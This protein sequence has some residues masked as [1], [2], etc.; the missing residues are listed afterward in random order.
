MKHVVKFTA[1]VCCSLAAAS[2]FADPET[3]WKQTGA[4][5]YVYVDPDNW[6]GGDV[7]GIF[8]SDLTLAGNQTITFSQDTTLPD[9]LTFQYD[10]KYAI[11]LASDGTGDK[12][13][14]LGGDI[15]FSPAQNDAAAT[16]TFNVGIDLGGAMRTISAGTNTKP[17][18][19]IMNAVSNGG[20]TLRNNYPLT[21]NSASTYAGGTT[22]AGTG[23]VT[24]MPDAFGTGTITFE[25]GSQLSVS[26]NRTFTVN[27]PLVF[28]GDWR[29]ALSGGNLNLGAGDIS[30][31][32]PVTVTADS[33][34]LTLGGAV[35]QG[36]ITDITK[37]GSGVLSTKAPLVLAGEAELCATAGTWQ[38]GGVISGAGTLV[39]TGAGQ[40]ELLASNTFTDI[41]VIREGSV[42]F[43]AK[44]TIA[45]GTR[46]L[47]ESAGELRSNTGSECNYAYSVPSLIS[48]G[49]IDT[50][51][52][53]TLAF[54]SNETGDIDLTNYPDLK[55]GISGGIF[56][57]T[58]VITAAPGRPYILG[59]GNTL[60]LASDNALSG[61]HDVVLNGS[62]TINGVNNVDG[63]VSLPVGYTFTVGNEAS[64][65]NAVLEADADCSVTFNAG[66]AGSFT[67]LKSLLLRTS[68]LTLGT[69]SAGAVEHIITDG[70]VVDTK[71][72]GGGTSQIAG[73]GSDTHATTLSLGTIV[74][75]ENSPCFL[76]ISATTL[77]DTI[78]IKCATPPDALA[79]NDTVGTPTTPVIPWI[80]ANGAVVKHT[81][82]DGFATLDPASDEAFAGSGAVTSIA[83]PGENLAVVAPA[84]VDIADATGDFNALSARY[85]GTD[86]TAFYA[87]NGTYRL[88]S[89][90]IDYTAYNGDE[91]HANLDLGANRGYFTG[92]I[93][94][95]KNA[96]GKMRLALTG[97]G[98]VSFSDCQASPT[99]REWDLHDLGSTYSGDTYLYCS[100][101]PKSTTIFPHG[102]DRTGDLYVY[103]KLNLVSCNGLRINGLNGKGSVASSGSGT[104][105]LIVG[106]DGAD[107]NYEGTF[108]NNP[109]GT[110]FG[111]TKEGAGRQRFSSDMGFKYSLEINGGILQLD[112]TTCLNSAGSSKENINV[113]A[114]GTLAGCGKIGGYSN[115]QVKN[116][117]VLAPGSAEIPNEPMVITNTDR[118]V[119]IPLQMDDGSALR[120]YIDNDRASQLIVSGAVTGTED[121]I[122]VTV[123]CTIQ[124][125]G[126]WMLLEADTF[127]EKVFA[128]TTK[129]AGGRLVVKTDETSN[130]EQLWYEQTAG[131]FMTIR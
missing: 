131:L 27:N 76:N 46:V 128:F 65:P 68:T 117:G 109:S 78:Q 72:N 85:S 100:I 75:A 1:L 35:V 108:V 49:M 24:V 11:T 59:G 42:R 97:T 41:F 47:I 53:G 79:A 121:S 70:I 30:I 31:P 43:R 16:V 87:T 23:A 20:L 93:S 10:G 26:G 8:G 19:K 57:Y 71:P 103:G 12:T 104:S 130:R 118:K 44:N 54:A 105:R 3:G 82:T 61:S 129:P 48:S 6:V 98:G 40:M 99:G 37:A 17:V 15:V 9:G 21:L 56:T 111:L 113:N 74:Q 34:T 114:G 96:T 112:G 101:H 91:F 22:L 39:K 50:D 119:S 13:L 89:G 64:L 88:L 7:N 92:M 83:T 45:A 32:A 67:R 127:N 126:A 25:Q 73:T 52:S 115:V 106:C 55:L 58:G 120:F 110:N 62:V 116:G 33:K 36:S 38:F 86:K 81:A 124:K 2:L 80:R 4:G 90:A 66:A 107:G 125:K 60:T 77:G 18:L 95:T 29:A 69:P 51:S 14:T 5:T 84:T 94:S 63:T 122:P 102:A 123:D 28:N